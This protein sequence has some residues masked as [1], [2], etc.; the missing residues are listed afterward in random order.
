MKKVYFGFALILSVFLIISAVGAE[1]I[2]SDDSN[3]CS[4]VVLMQVEGTDVLFMGDADVMAEEKVLS[5]M[6]EPVDILQ[7][8]HHGSANNTNSEI[9]LRTLNPRISVISCGFDNIYGH[10]HQETLEK[11]NAMNTRIIRT[12]QTG[13]V[14]FWFDF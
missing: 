11:L 14:L 2:I 4:L 5:F 13:E 3:A 9:F 1:E 6:S 12:D 8:A 7:V 10:P